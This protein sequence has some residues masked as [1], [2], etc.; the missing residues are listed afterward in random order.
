MT[1][2]KVM[3]EAKEKYEMQLQDEDEAV[4]ED[5]KMHAMELFVNNLIE[6]DPT[7]DLDEVEEL[8]QHELDELTASFSND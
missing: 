4:Q 5:A 2:Q 1:K 6:Q 3:Q 7:S 8:T